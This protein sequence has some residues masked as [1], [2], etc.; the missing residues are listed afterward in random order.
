MFGWVGRPAL[1][2][3]LAAVI[4]TTLQGTW[5]TDNILFGTMLNVLLAASVCAGIVGGAEIGALAGFI[6]GLSYDL[7]L[8]TPF[9]LSAM[10]FGLAAY[11]VGLIKASI[12][13]VNVWWLT[14]ILALVGTLLGVWTMAVVLVLVDA[15]S[16]LPRSLIG[17]SIVMAVFNALISPGMERVQR[18]TWRISRPS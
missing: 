11:A 2:V 9:G 16:E 1:R 7:L 17:P 4:L 5:F 14:M 3:A 10:A 15:A 18:W 6:F 13:V 8:T 12:T